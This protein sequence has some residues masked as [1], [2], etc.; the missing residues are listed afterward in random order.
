MGGESIS[1][2]YERFGFRDY[3]SFFKAFKKEYGMSPKDYQALYMH[4]PTS[5]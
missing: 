2:T 3:S 4:S 1:K 5:G